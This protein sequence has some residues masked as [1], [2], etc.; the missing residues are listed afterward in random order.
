MHNASSIAALVVL[1]VIA[2]FGQNEHQHP[3]TSACSK[4]SE[5]S[6]SESIG[7]VP[8]ELLERPL[9]LRTGL[10]NIHEKVSTSSAEAQAYYD[11]GLRYL[12]SYVWIEAARAFNQALRIDAGLA[13]AYVGLSRAYSGLEDQEKALEA[14]QKAQQLAS[15]VSDWERRRV[16]LRAM[17]VDAIRDIGN[18]AKH[19]AY[20]TAIEA[21]LSKNPEDVELWLLLGNASE[22]T[23]A[24][25]GQRGTA[26]SIA[27]YDEVLRR[28][29]DNIAAHHYLV[30]SYETIGLPEEAIKHGEVY[31]RLTPGVAHAQHMYGHDLQKVNRN[32]EA[33]AQFKKAN[34]IEEAYYKNEN[35]PPKYDWHHMHNLD[36]MSVSYQYEGR[37]KE[38]G[39]LWLQAW[40]LPPVDGW[41]E[42]YKGK[43][44]EFL[45]NTD[46]AQDA[47]QYAR[48]LEQG[49][50]AVGRTYAHV[51]AARALLAL[52]RISEAKQES[53]AADA[54][55]QRVEEFNSDPIMPRPRELPAMQMRVLHGEFALR[56]GPKEEAE[57]TF[58]GVEQGILAGSR[59]AETFSNLFLLGYIAKEA[60]EKGDW[61]LADQ[62]A[63][64]MLKFDPNYA[65]GHLALA[66][67]LSHTGD[68]STAQTEY[69]T[70]IKRWSQADPDMT[71]MKL[72]QVVTAN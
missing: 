27:I 47:L 57:A 65:G 67:V 29:P 60:R 52:N 43:F 37:I 3:Q 54:E 62:T 18:E 41:W 44:P 46:R 28:S 2:C 69:E 32:E 45:L 23:A 64:A 22:P 58:A 55:L 48:E 4:Q 53:A 56:E 59:Q 50:W 38:A 36:L 71:E 11:Q 31:A 7:W 12:H 21:A 17:Q 39:Q 8:R 16:A 6:D 14:V 33:I 26:D 1:L 30:H 70:A 13:M 9:P 25:R 35:I 42:V 10:G 49:R 61:K 68:K 34:A 40:M 72:L 51:I 19:L 66:L 20:R 15:H 5:M 63:R 24:G